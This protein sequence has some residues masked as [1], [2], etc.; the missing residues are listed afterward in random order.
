MCE[1]KAQSRKNM[2]SKIFYEVAA[3]LVGFKFSDVIHAETR[4]PALFSVC[5]RLYVFDVPR[6][7]DTWSVRLYK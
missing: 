7:R 2:K 6:S 1:T 3:V 4:Q 5:V